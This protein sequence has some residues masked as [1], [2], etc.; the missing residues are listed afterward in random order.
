[1]VQQ[2]A[3]L[4]DHVRLQMQET[5]LTSCIPYLRRL[6]RQPF[7]AR[8]NWKGSTFSYFESLGV[9]PVWGELEPLTSHTAL[10]RRLPTEL[11]RR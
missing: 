6:E 4:F 7:A 3:P 11:T 10:W 5:G 9:G 8:C 1:M 2:P